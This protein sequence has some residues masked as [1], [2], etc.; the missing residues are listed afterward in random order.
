MRCQLTSCNIKVPTLFV[1]TNRCRCGQTYC[2][3]H[4]LPELHQCSWD[5]KKSG[6]EELT[7]KLVRVEAE[8]VTPIV[9]FGMEK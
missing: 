6:R 3:K 4:R 9:G 7:R 2:N 8:K 5:F 1:E